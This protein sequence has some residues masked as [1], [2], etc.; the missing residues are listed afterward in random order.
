MVI[1]LDVPVPRVLE[2]IKKRAISYE[3]DSPVLNAQ[4]LQVIEKQYKQ[5]YLKEIR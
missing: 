1:Y 2:N 4:Y 5:N 3:K